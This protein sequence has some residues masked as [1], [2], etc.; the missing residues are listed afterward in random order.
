MAIKEE[1][2]QNEQFLLLSPCFQLCSIIVLSFKGSSQ[3]FSGIFSKASA[4]DLMNEGKGYST[5]FF[6]SF[7][8]SPCQASSISKC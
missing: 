2:A 3:F 5:V 4:A 7:V 1:I 6:L 8:F